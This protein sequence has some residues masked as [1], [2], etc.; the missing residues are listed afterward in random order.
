[1]TGVLMDIILI[2]ISCVPLLSLEPLRWYFCTG[3]F[4]GLRKAFWLSFSASVLWSWLGDYIAAVYGWHWPFYALLATGAALCAL[5]SRL[6]YYE[7]RRWQ[8]EKRPGQRIAL[9]L[10]AF[11]LVFVLASWLIPESM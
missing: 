6:V 7:E 8:R 4:Q 9:T 11:L 3:N 2:L 10:G 5:C 1:M